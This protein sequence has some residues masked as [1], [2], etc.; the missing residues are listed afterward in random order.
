MALQNH[1]AVAS[2]A[3]GGIFATFLL[4]NSISPIGPILQSNLHLTSLELGLAL[5]SFLW[6]YTLLQPLAGWAADTYGAKTTLLVGVLAASLV[7]ILTG[8]ATSLI[9]LIGFRIALGIAQ[10]PNFV[11][12]AK[13]SSS[14]WIASDHRAR[15]TSVW[16]VGGRLGT[17]VS[18]PLA[19]IL[20]VNFG[21]QWAFF[22]S[23]FLGLVWCAVWFLGFQNNPRDIPNAK[24]PVRERLRFRE[25]LPTLISPLGLGLALASFGQGYLAY[26]LTTWLPTDFVGEQK[27]TVLAAGLFAV[28][29]ILSA[30]FTI[31]AIGG[32]LSDYEVKRG[33]NQVGF[34]R[35]LF[36]LGMICASV[37]FFITAYAPTIATVTSLRFISSPYFAVGTLSL[38]G[39]SWGVAT[40]SLW[41]ALVE[42]TPKEVTG[43]MGGIMNF[44]GNLGGIVIL[45]LAGYS[46]DVT[47]HSSF[48]QVTI[49]MF[50]LLAAVSALLLIKPRNLSRSLQSW[51]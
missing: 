9:A 30:V 27:F 20:A 14:N 19:A 15:A 37:F 39:A 32:F 23:G 34:R 17:A 3:G 45:I 43:S 36:S 4:R 46:L 7:T 21:W 51:A 25:S 10:S 50:A 8:F 5:S 40:P 24:L 22:G 49:G 31:I 11:T 38:A 6:V 42:A 18:I 35:K 47:K 12:G 33:A 44:G 28:L 29:P 26:Y 1:W 13:V 16:I 48:A 2:L 41:A